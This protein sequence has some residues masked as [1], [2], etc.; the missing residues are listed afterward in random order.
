MS[1]LKKTDD[2]V[3]LFDRIT[4]SLLFFFVF[5]PVETVLAQSGAGRNPGNVISDLEALAQ[6]EEQGELDE[7]LSDFEEDSPLEP[8]PTQA[9][10]SQPSWPTWI[11][12]KGGLALGSSINFAH[13][14]PAAGRTDHRGISRL[15]T[16]A[17]LTADYRFSGTW[18]ART[19]VKGFYDFAYRINGHE[20]YTEAVISLYEHE[21]E[22]DDFY[23]HGNL[24]QNLDVKIGRQVVVWGKSDNIRVTDILNPLDNREPGLVDIRDLRLPVTMTRLDYFSGK[25]SLSPVVVHEIR[26]NKN[27][28]FD[29]DFFPGN[30]PSPHEEE[31]GTSLKNQEFGLALNGIFSGWDLSF[32]SAY[33]FNDQ[34]NLEPTITPGLYI[35]KHARIT[36]AGMALN[37]AS[38]NWLFKGETAYLDGFEFS[39]QPGDDKK[40]ADIL[41]GVEYSGFSETTISLEAVNR[42]I[43]DY[44]D[45]MSQADHAQKDE[46]QSVFRISKDFWYDRLTITGLFAT[47]DLTGDDGGFQRLTCEYDWS[48]ALSITAGLITYKSG[49]KFIYNDI[50]DND[51][52]FLEF[53]YSFGS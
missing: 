14:E 10:K 27:P 19:T 11:E 51:R 18:K 41:L 5:Y 25:W 36:M 8:I 44:H 40:R 52:F 7:I 53:R 42:H 26:F 1:Q 45:S 33:V 23:V 12:L 35:L 2:F 30:Q 29:S 22:I 47:F 38:G 16:S 24:S 43:F 39:S 4:I 48:D 6:A 50:G 31:P 28:V 46:F 49:D 34:A 15:K 32:Y 9:D 21:G 20:N 37:I 13:E 3:S 17:D